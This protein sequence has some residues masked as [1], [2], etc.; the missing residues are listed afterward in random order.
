VIDYVGRV[1]DVGYRACEQLYKGEAA[2]SDNCNANCET[3][4]KHEVH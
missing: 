3:L 2:E 4:D 1:G